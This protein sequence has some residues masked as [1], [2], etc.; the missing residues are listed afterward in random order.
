LSNAP[1]TNACWILATP[2]LPV[3]SEES[4]FYLY[5]ALKKASDPVLYY[6]F[7]N[8]YGYDDY[9]GCGCYNVSYDSETTT[10]IYGGETSG[11]GTANVT[12]WYSLR[13]RITT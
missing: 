9:Y 13:T 2:S 11:G 5:T 3:F 10:S 7:W 8:Y 4:N 12:V 6:H 1:A